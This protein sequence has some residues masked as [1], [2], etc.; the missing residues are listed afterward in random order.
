MNLQ[1]ISYFG[2]LIFLLGLFGISFYKSFLSILISFQLLIISALINFFSFSLFLY[3]ESVWDKTFTL[4][5]IIS[6]YLL[7]FSIVYYNFAA[8][9]KL[10]DKAL[11]K[12]R[13]NY[14]LFKLDK[15]DWWGEDT[16]GD[17]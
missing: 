3:S 11:F 15:S 2:F 16:L 4:L 5:S 10:I 1:I 14:F 6:V 7:M 9:G 12:S 17:N 13:D 8:D